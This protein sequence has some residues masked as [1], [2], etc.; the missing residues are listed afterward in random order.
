MN[1]QENDWIIPVYKVVP[2]FANPVTDDQ[3]KFL[4][5]VPKQICDF[6]ELSAFRAQ[7]NNTASSS[8]ADRCALNKI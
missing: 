4:D 5:T 7:N 8:P 1:I 2:Q 6:F 3:Q